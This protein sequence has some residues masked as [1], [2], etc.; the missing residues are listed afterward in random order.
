MR[1]GKGRELHRGHYRAQQGAYQHTTQGREGGVEGLIKQRWNSFEEALFILP[2]AECPSPRKQQQQSSE[3][4][5][6]SEAHVRK[7]KLS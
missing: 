6:V 4:R 2:T 3:L 7:L 5:L 1:K